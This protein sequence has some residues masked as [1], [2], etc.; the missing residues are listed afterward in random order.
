[1]IIISQDKK[2]IINFDNVTRVFIDGPEE[3]DKDKK[4]YIGADTNSAESMVWELGEYETEAR[5]KEVLKNIWISYGNEKMINIPKIEIHQTL[6]ADA[7]IS[8]ICY[9]MPEK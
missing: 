9:Q 3:D 2:Q 4:Y 8:N 7:L 1:M 5:A 6:L